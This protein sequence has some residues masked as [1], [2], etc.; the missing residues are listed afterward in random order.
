[1]NCSRAGSCDKIGLL[2]NKKTVKIT[3]DLFFVYHYFFHQLAVK[4]VDDLFWLIL[5]IFHQL[6]VQNR[7]ALKNSGRYIFH[8]GKYWGVHF[9]VKK[10]GSYNCPLFSPEVT[11]TEGRTV[12]HE[13]GNK[14]HKTDTTFKG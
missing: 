11:P 13:T 8:T 14:R 3:D 10:G 4:I 12:C 6:A 9:H 1:V 5:Y 7:A 2:N